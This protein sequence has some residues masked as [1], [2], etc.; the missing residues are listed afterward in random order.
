M[1]TTYIYHKIGVCHRLEIILTKEHVGV[2][3]FRV[4]TALQKREFK[5]LLVQPKQ[6]DQGDRFPSKSVVYV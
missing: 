3:L 6:A 1:F 4:E 2:K 5:S